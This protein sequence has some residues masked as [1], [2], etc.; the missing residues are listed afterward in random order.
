M[1]VLVGLSSATFAQDKAKLADKKAVAVNKVCPVSGEEI[2]PTI[3]VQYKDKAY[4]L[5]C[6]KCTAK[7]MKNPEKYIKKTDKAVK[8]KKTS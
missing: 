1:F 4:G 6:N 2:D 8:G 7:F 3:V 5:C